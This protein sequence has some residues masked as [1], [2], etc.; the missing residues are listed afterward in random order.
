MRCQTE[1]YSHPPSLRALLIHSLST[2]APRAVADLHA[3][4]CRDGSS[5]MDT[6]IS[7]HGVHCAALGSCSTTHRAWRGQGH[8]TGLAHRVGMLHA[9]PTAPSLHRQP[10]A[11][12][13]QHLLTLTSDGAS[14][15]EKCSNSAAKAAQRFPAERAELPQFQAILTATSAAEICCTGGEVG[16]QTRSAKLELVAEEDTAAGMGTLQPQ[17]CHQCPPQHGHSWKQ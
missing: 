14:A 8:H 3:Q 4:A 7:T 1:V 10:S 11:L 13:P 9:E 6:S 2:T 5:N 12:H 15:G 17:H 16:S